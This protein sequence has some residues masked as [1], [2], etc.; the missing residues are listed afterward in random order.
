M[1]PR[2]ISH[3]GNI[4]GRDPEKENTEEYIDTARMLGFDVE[5]DVWKI[6]DSLYLGHDYPKYEVNKEFIFM[7]EECLLCHAKNVSALE[8]LTS[9]DVHC[10]WHNK[11]DYTMTNKG[12]IIAYPGMS[13]SS[14]NLIVMKPEFHSK[15]MGKCFALCSDYIYK[16]RTQ[17]E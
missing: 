2:F 6:A 11:D 3:R 15:K 7:H 17:Y 1:M 13:C 16:Y 10:F 12:K 9:N 8:W 14:K 4:D 5:I